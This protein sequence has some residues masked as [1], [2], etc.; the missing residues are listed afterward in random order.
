MT[1][2]MKIL[3]NTEQIVIGE[4]PTNWKLVIQWDCSTLILHY[5]LGNLRKIKRITSLQKIN[6]WIEMEKTK[7]KQL[8]Q[9]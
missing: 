6:F 2:F 5:H 9:Y 1:C 4:I 7:I 3:T 8:K